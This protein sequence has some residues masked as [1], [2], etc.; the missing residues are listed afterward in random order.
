MLNK[1]FVAHA[2]EN[3]KLEDFQNP[4]IHD[5]HFKW[6]STGRIFFQDDFVERKILTKEEV[7]KIEEQVKDLSTN[8]FNLMNSR[9]YP[10]NKEC[11]ETFGMDIMID[12]TLTIKLLEVQIT[13]ISYGF[14]DD[15]RL[16][17]YSN[18]FE[19]ILDN[20]METVVDPIFPPKNKVP[21]I[22]AFKLFYKKHF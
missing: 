1:I 2:L 13:N 19:Y 9:C 16:P 8:V 17:G 7:A 20:A 15:D 22:G 14:F 12:Q 11:Y 5:T 6:T 18:I 3:F 21:R 4:H 10:E